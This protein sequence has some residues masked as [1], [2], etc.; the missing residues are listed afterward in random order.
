MFP[1]CPTRPSCTPGPTP[2][3]LLPSCG[4]ID[5]LIALAAGVTAG[6]S[7][8]PAAWE[9][10]EP[11]SASASGPGGSTSPS[12]GPAVG[13]RT[14]VGSGG[15]ASGSGGSA[16]ADGTAGG[17]GGGGSSGGGGGSEVVILVPS[18][19]LKER[20]RQRVAAVCGGAAEVLVLTAL[21]SKGLEFKVRWTL[22]SLLVLHNDQVASIFCKRSLS[23]RALLAHR[24]PVPALAPPGSLAVRLL[25]LLPPSPQRQV[26]PA[27]P[28][29]GA[30]GPA[31]PG[32]NRTGRLARLPLFR[33]PRPRAHG[34]GA[35]GAVR[36]RDTCP[37]GRGGGGERQG[38]VRPGAGAV[39][40]E[41]PGGRAGGAGGGCEWLGQ[42][43][44]AGRGAGVWVHS[45]EG[46]GIRFSAA[47]DKSCWCFRLRQRTA[48]EVGCRNEL[49]STLATRAAPPPP[50]TTS[51]PQ[52]LARL[53]R[54]MSEA[55]LRQRA[56][57]LFS[58]DMFADAMRLFE[59]LGAWERL[60]TVATRATRLRTLPYP[61]PAALRLARAPPVQRLCAAGLKY[62]SRPL[63]N[64]W[65]KRSRAVPL[66]CTRRATDAILALHVWL[67]T[68]CLHAFACGH[69]RRR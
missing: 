52:V 8:G 3:F 66:L 10:G 57:Q 33:A 63:V 15:A 54:R 67:T 42:G 37:G 69:V 17:G 44:G 20:L 5:H 65:Y 51:P 45:A 27:A 38:G 58:R 24:A 59:R 64:W 39:G 31:A 2:L 28:P 56:E 48:L 26:A 41:G 6:V 29:P 61:E 50:S 11:A 47:T 23:N 4:D 21:E 25:L 32:G 35:Q 14:A 19:E 7:A 16:G 43:A 40:Q 60:G 49:Q 36:G 68:G 9:D 34:S 18:E 1:V 46:C 62:R 30:H 12:K 13:S 55:E 53:Q 22:G